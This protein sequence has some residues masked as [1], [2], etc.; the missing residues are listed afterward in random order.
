MHTDENREGLLTAADMVLDQCAVPR[1][2][3]AAQKTLSLPY[4][5][6]FTLVVP[7]GDTITDAKRTID[8]ANEFW[9]RAISTD[10]VDGS[11]E[12]NVLV[13]FI[14]PGGRFT[15]NARIR[16][17]LYMGTGSTRKLIMPQERFLPGSKITIELENPGGADVAI[18]LLFEGAERYYFG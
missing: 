16:L 14:R 1:P 5:Y 15:S 7:A 13:R 18:T 2:P 17:G 3:V 12:G 4:C 8:R 11:P 6:K 9:L 10:A